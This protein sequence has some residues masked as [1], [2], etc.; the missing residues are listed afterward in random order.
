[1]SQDHVSAADMRKA[2][3]LFA[4][5]GDPVR[6]AMVARLS[7]DGPLATIELK[8]DTGVSRQAIT[9]HLQVLENAGLVKSDR[10]GRDR[11][12]R[13]QVSQVTAA[14]GYLDQ[15]SKQWD[16][17]LERLKAIVEAESR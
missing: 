9:K 1:M 14:R 15:I 16:L 5:L 4:A 17:R 10:V 3:P 8:R 2:A 6:L 13:M 12:W 7:G 11:Q